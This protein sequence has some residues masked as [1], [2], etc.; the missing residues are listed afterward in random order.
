[1]IGGLCSLMGV[2]KGRRLPSFLIKVV[3]KIMGAAVVP[4]VHAHVQGLQ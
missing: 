4:K 1:M 3:V 2:K